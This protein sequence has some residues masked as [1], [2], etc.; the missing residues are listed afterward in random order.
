MELQLL[1]QKPIKIINNFIIFRSN[2]EKKYH[3]SLKTLFL[4]YII[5]RILEFPGACQGST[6]ELLGKPRR[7]QI[8]CLKVALPLTWILDQL[9]S[10][11]HV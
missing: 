9:L 6:L 5:A 11:N 7:P 10:P 4:P 3:K 1:N 8:L 2:H